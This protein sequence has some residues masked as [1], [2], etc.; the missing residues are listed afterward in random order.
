[1]GWVPSASCRRRCPAALNREH[2]DLDGEPE[3]DQVGDHL[4]GDD[5][6]CGLGSGRDVSE[7]DGG[8]HRDGEVHH[9]GAG[10][11]LAEAVDGEPGHDEVGAGEQHQ[12]QWTF[13]KSASGARRPGKWWG[14]DRADLEGDQPRR[15]SPVR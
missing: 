6:P 10:Q 7:R 8:E 5:E 9:A 3:D 15:T 2:D 12:E 11:R 14:E 1:M 4:P 13:V